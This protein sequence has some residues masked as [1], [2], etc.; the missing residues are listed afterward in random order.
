MIERL[1]GSPVVSASTYVRVQDCSLAASKLPTHTHTNT[2]A[3]ERGKGG[4]NDLRLQGSVAQNHSSKRRDGGVRVEG[5]GSLQGGSH[6]RRVPQNSGRRQKACVVV[7]SYERANSAGGSEAMGVVRTVDGRN[8]IR[9]MSV[10]K[11]TF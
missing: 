9:S 2:C 1:A 6:D 3:E 5:E 7:A 11:S 8:L 10:H 4:E